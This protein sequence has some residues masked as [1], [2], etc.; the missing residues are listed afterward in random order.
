MESI[1]RVDQ[2]RGEADAIAF[3]AKTTFQNFLHIQF[4]PNFGYIC[5]FSLKRKGR[6]AR[7]DTE[8]L[9]LRQRIENFFADAIAKIFLIV[10]LAQINK[11]QHSDGSLWN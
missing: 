1:T 5:I 4:L 9:H 7:D 11:G 8:T 2:L 6:S 3:A 10:R